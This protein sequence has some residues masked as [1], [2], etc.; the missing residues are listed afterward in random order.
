MTKKPYIEM[1]EEP[2]RSDAVVAKE[3]WDAFLA[4]NRSIIVDL[5][6]GQ[7][8]STV[9]CL[10]C[11]RIATNFD[12]FLSVQLPIPDEEE[13][14][15]SQGPKK[16][17]CH[18][19]SKDMHKYIASDDDYELKPVKTVELTLQPSMTIRDFKQKIIN[20]TGVDAEPK[21]VKVCTQAKGKILQIAENKGK[22]SQLEL[23]KCNLMLYSV[24]KEKPGDV[25]V[26]LNFWKRHWQSKRSYTDKEAKDSLP[27]LATFNPSQSFFEIKQQLA[28][29]MRGCFKED[30]AQDD[31]GLNEAIEI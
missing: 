12:P 14:R 28:K 9:T 19:V 24:P 21:E 27:R 7:L 31:E 4:R 15:V 2:N 3:F 23:D 8:K 29:M 25:V 10:S 5:M 18:Y 30:P 1:S 13:S 11:G 17:K 16:L 20:E 22:L 26:E 6:Y